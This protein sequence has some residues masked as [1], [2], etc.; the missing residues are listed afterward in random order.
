MLYRAAQFYAH[1]CH[2]VAH[3]PTFLQDHEWF[4]E[5]YPAYETA[6]DRLMEQMI[7]LRMEP[8]C[9]KVLREAA[10]LANEMEC[11]KQNADGFKVLLNFEKQFRNEIA[12][13]MKTEKRDGTQNLL[14]DLATA[15][16]H[17][18][19]LIGQRVR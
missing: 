16:D 2:L 9:H 11:P 5:L 19:Y 4:G 12:A 14:Q 6:F 1:H 15:S 8:D 17:R 3:G 13:L 7:G 18:T 10:T